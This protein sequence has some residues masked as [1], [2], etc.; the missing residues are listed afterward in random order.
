LSPE[1]RPFFKRVICP[2]RDANSSAAK[3]LA[4]LGAE[5][6][7][8]DPASAQ[9]WKNVLKGVDVVVNTMAGQVVDVNNL[10]ADAAVESGVKVYFP[11]EFGVDHRINDFPGFDHPEW[12]RKRVQTEHVQEVSAGKM[13]IVFLY[14]GLFVEY[15]GYPYK[16]TFGPSG[17][18]GFDIGNKIFTA[19]GSPTA[20]VAFTSKADIGRTLAQLSILSMSPTTAST[21]PEHVR[22]CGTLKSMDEIRLAMEKES[23]ATINGR[24]LELGKFKNE[25]KAAFLGGEATLNLSPSQH[26]CILMGEGKLDWSLENHNN[27]VNPHESIWKWKTMEE[28]AKATKG[29]GAS[30]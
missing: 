5:V 25:L 18:F 9:A 7:Q 27:L 4:D 13:K 1:Y 16:D 14:I 10:I 29:K 28:F 20:R 21:V 12:A 3:A 2:T 24:T 15:V 26:I 23:G 8:V 6:R 22:I 19:V 11:S 17:W 30:N